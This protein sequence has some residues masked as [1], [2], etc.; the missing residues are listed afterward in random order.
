MKLPT[1]KIRTGTL[2]KNYILRF[3]PLIGRK[4]NSL[5]CQIRLLNVCYDHRRLAA[6]VSRFKLVP[7]GSLLRV[8][9]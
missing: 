8:T 6:G 5:T 9:D 2:L 7:L 4:K 3:S 1:V